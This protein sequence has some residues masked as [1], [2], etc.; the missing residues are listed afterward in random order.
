MRPYSLDLRQKIIEVYT[1]E[2]IS[3]RQ[4][5]IRFKVALSFVQKLI[6]QYDNTGDIH[7]RPHGGGKKLKLTEEQLE[8][9]GEI[10]SKNNDATLEELCKLLQE[11]TTVKISRATMGRMMQRLNFTFKKKNVTG[12]RARHGTGSTAQSR[13]LAVAEKY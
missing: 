11:R 4:L 9:L 1:K 5:S 2:K 12:H 6:K 3:G 10:V 7:P 8:V 13:V